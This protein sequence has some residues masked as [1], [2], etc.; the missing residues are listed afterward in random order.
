MGKVRIGTL[1]P[2]VFRTGVP[3]IEIVREVKCG[4]CG[5]TPSLRFVRIPGNM[6]VPKGKSCMGIQAWCPDH[7]SV[8]VMSTEG[9]NLPLVQQAIATVK[10]AEAQKADRNDAE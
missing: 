3:E 6:R 2:R 8:L 10:A 4:V 9:V 7:G 5:K 1:D